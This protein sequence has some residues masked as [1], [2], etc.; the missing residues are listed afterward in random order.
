MPYMV[1]DGVSGYLVGPED[2]AALSDRMTRILADDSLRAKMGEQARRTAL[3]R[4]HPDV[5]ARKTID[6]YQA[7]VRAGG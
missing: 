3:S 4:F 2:T 1:D 5:V 6:V 7:L